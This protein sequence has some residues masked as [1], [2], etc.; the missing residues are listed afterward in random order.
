MSNILR[1]QRLMWILWP[2]F[3]V[4]CALE[5]FVFALLDPEGMEFMGQPLEWSRNTV[6]SVTF[7]LF[8]LLT[9]TSSALTTLLA[10]S[11][12]EI[13]RCPFDPNQ[14]PEVCPKERCDC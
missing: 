5:L 10:R 7:F 13:N 14:R 9:G 8:W 2:S 3:L 6:Y 4:A 11:P 12:F 1:D